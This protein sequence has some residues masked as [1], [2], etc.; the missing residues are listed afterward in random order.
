MPNAILPS[1]KPKIYLKGACKESISPDSFFWTC[2]RGILNMMSL[3]QACVKSSQ[4]ILGPTVS[5]QPYVPCQ[6][7]VSSHYI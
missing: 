6:E 1:R 7:R 2:L 5:I 4:E 3:A